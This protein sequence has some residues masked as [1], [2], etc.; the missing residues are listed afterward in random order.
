M[1]IRDRNQSGVIDECK[2]LLTVVLLHDS[3]G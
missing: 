1:K 3:R 2:E